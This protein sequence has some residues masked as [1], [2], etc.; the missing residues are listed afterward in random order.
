MLTWD[1]GF[2]HGSV[3]ELEFNSRT[4]NVARFRHQE[5]ISMK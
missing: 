4:R 5:K 2:M 3:K 1:L